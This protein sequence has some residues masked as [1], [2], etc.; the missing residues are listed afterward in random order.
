MLDSGSQNAYQIEVTGVW[1]SRKI[2]S[3]QSVNVEY[4]G[5]ALKPGTAYGWKIRVWDEADEV[6]AWSNPALWTRGIFRPEHWK[7]QWISTEVSP[8]SPSPPG[9]KPTNSMSMEKKSGR[10]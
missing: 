3:D 6:S 7:A 2:V 9:G 1:D 4:G 8:S 10:T 5:P